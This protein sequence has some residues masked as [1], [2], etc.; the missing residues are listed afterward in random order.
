MIAAIVCLVVGFAILMGYVA[1]TEHVRT[2]QQEKYWRQEQL[3]LIAEH[4]ARQARKR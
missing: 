4:Y 1:Y 2:E 3:R